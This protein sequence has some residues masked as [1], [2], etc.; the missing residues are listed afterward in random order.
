M[1]ARPLLLRAGAQGEEPVRR[2]VEARVLLRDDAPT[3]QPHQRPAHV[4]LA[5]HAVAVLVPLPEEV[6]HAGRV[7]DERLLELGLGLGTEVRLGLG[8]ELGLGLRLEL[9]CGLG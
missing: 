4:A 7:L 8:L 9:Q 5:H 3:A 6:D 1:E 2:L